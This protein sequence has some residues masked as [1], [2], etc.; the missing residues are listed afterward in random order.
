MMRISGIC[1]LADGQ[2]LPGAMGGFPPGMIFGRGV[3]QL[4]HMK[5]ATT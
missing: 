2:S 1:I 4:G 3:I 5:E